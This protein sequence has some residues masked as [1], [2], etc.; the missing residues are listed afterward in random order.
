[1]PSRTRDEW[2]ALGRDLRR[3]CPRSAHGAWSA[4]SDR[5]DPVALLAESNRTRLADL[6]SVRN[7]RMSESPFTFFRGAPA[8][9]ASDLGGTP[10]TG[11]QIQICG[12]AHLLN[13]GTYA[14]PER[15]LVFDVNDFDETHLGPWEWDL[16][17]LAASLVVAART[18]GVADRDGTQA[19]RGASSAYR[20]TM[21]LLAGLSPFEVW[22]ARVDADAIVARAP[23]KQT[24]ADVEKILTKARQRTSLDALSK[25]TTVTDGRRVIVEDPPLVTRMPG[26]ELDMAK[27]FASAYR[28]TLDP[29]RRLLLD[30]YEFV[31]A[32]RKVV[33]VGSV[34]TRC[35]VVL[36]AGSV[37][38]DP[39]FLQ[40]K[41]AQPSVLAPYVRGGRYYNQGLRVVAGQRI[42]QSASD[43]FLGWGRVG[44]FDAYVRQLRDMKGS[45]PIGA[46]TRSALADYGR[47]CGATLA[48]AHA[49]AGEPSLLAGYLGTGPVFDDALAVFAVAYADQNERDYESFVRAVKSGRLDAR[50]GG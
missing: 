45:L 24:R 11:V 48:H 41:E 47:L 16:R 31:D 49:R 13:F 15:N 20:S 12:D 30:R 34:G 50:P 4:A 43:V 8:V 22:H 40:I 38:L 21:M 26:D 35:Y 25:L 19:V 7:E 5:L 46:L 2:R 14:T 9:M 17:R 27:R 36:L 42:M 6:V 3:R 29:D 39:L 33:G 44:G 37:D 32:A 28:R 18:A 1:M 23:T 10:S